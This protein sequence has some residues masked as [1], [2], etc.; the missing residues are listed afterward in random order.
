[1]N[2]MRV[3]FDNLVLMVEVV[4]AVLLGLW[5][6]SHLSDID[7]QSTESEQPV[8]IQVECH[9]IGDMKYSQF[10]ANPVCKREE[11]KPNEQ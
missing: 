1:M 2:T 3:I 7:Y 5:L 6:W 8:I 4:A 9:H 10:R 11:S